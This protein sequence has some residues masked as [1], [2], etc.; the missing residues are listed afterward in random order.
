MASLKKPLVSKSYWFKCWRENAA[1]D[2]GDI[3]RFS[4]EDPNTGKRIGFAS[5]ESLLAYVKTV[6]AQWEEEA[7]TYDDREGDILKPSSGEHKNG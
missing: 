3:W 1:Q 6:L 5:L 7:Q 4:L 2:T